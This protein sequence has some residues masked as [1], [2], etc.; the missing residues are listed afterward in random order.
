MSNLE[1]TFIIL[2]IFC[3][4]DVFFVIYPYLSGK[5]IPSSQDD[6]FG[7]I[8]ANILTQFPINFLPSQIQ[9]FLPTVLSYSGLHLY[10]IMPSKA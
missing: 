7:S 2:G 3:F 9:F 6:D 1:C 10:K 5:C 8:V 4:V